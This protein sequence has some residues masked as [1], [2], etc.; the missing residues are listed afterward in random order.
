MHTI[1]TLLSCLLLLSACATNESYRGN[2]NYM[3]ETKESD[4][5][6][7]MRYLTGR[8]IPRND[9]K[10]FSH[11]LTAANEGNP[12]AQNEVAYLY[13]TGKGTTQDYTKAFEYYQKAARRNLSSAQYSL[14]LF[15]Q[16]GLG[17]V[18]NHT[19]ACQL[20][21]KSK[22][23]GFEPAKRACLQYCDHSTS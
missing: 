18:P 1:L 10:A 9:E 17:Q 4:T 16:Y 12:F 3:Q 21:L 6:L 23:S 7:G 8:G 14:G 19:K 5:H 13:A 15:Y 20:F 11:L 2:I 22:R